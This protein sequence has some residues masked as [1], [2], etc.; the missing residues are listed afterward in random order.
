MVEFCN[1]NVVLGKE[2][3]EMLSNWKI[4]I[5]LVMM[6]LSSGVGKCIGGIPNVKACVTCTLGIF[7]FHVT[8]LNP[9]PTIFLFLYMNVEELFVSMNFLSLQV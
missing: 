2:D 4:S 9:K 3:R 1:Y 5:R 8:F 6:A 7:K